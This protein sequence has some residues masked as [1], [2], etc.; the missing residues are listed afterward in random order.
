MTRATKMDRM[1]E[2]ARAVRGADP[3]GGAEEAIF[4]IALDRFETD[5][6]RY[7]DVFEWSFT[8]DGRGTDFAR[9]S[10]GFPGWRSDTSVA[11]VLRA[12]GAAVGP[13][14]RDAADA[15]ARAGRDVAVEQVLVGWARGVTGAAPRLKLYLQIDARR[16]AR[17]LA[18]AR[19]MLGRA[20]PSAG[21]GRLHL[22]GLDVGKDGLAGAKLYYAEPSTTDDRSRSV[23]DALGGAPDDLLA[24]QR[25]D[26]PEAEVASVD[27]I[28]FA[29]SPACPWASLRERALLAPFAG[30][31]RAFAQR[32]SAFRLRVRRAS[33]GLTSPKVNVYYVLDEAA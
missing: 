18:L 2:L 28:D 17:G 19:A 25:I 26:D 1:R 13:A 10:Y 29:I 24:I 14:G 9:F 27:E 5:R 7:S 3:G 6:L 23:L 15:L 31:L 20:V 11:E 30:A 16:G 33:L 22:V 32:E 4:E 12:A 8:S 21:P